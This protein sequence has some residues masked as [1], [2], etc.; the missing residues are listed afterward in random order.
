MTCLA[1]KDYLSIQDLLKPK[2]YVW[3]SCLKEAETDL[4]KSTVGINGEEVYRP[5]LRQSFSIKNRFKIVYGNPNFVSLFDTFHVGIGSCHVYRKGD[6]LKEHQDAR[7]SNVEIKIKDKIISLPH[8]MTMIITDDPTPLKINGKKMDQ[9]FERYFNSYIFLFS[10]NLPHEVE[11]VQK[12]RISFVFP[13]YGEY[14]PERLASRIEVEPFNLYNYVLKELNKRLTRC[15]KDR[16]ASSEER[17]VDDTDAMLQCYIEKIKDPS[18]VQEFVR[19]RAVFEY[20]PTER[21]HGINMSDEETYLE[22]YIEDCKEDGIL[23]PKN[24]RQIKLLKRVIKIVQEEKQE[25]EERE[26]KLEEKQRMG[27]KEKV[28]E[29]K[30][31]LEKEPIVRPFLVMLKGRY[32]PESKIEDLSYLDESSLQLLKDLGYDNITFLPRAANLLDFRVFNVKNGELFA[33][34]DDMRKGEICDAYPEFDDQGGYDLK[35]K[36]V[37]GFLLVS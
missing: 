5:D 33:S 8:I 10:L 17:F 12:T 9:I 3:E 28:L 20:V 21:C 26:R 32:L 35:Y 14:R 37:H 36:L 27:K 1:F 11:P 34:E 25:E 29:E 18:A 22:R 30:K 4:E 24:L 16:E 13:V 23:K 19:Y 6:F 2:D 7:L 31:N 15:L